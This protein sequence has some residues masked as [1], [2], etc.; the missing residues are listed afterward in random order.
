MTEERRQA[1]I[2]LLR[3][4]AMEGARP[5]ALEAH[6]VEKLD[7]HTARILSKGL[8]ELLKRLDASLNA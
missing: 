1:A 8:D 4:R 2:E 3:S 7:P 5:H 6:A